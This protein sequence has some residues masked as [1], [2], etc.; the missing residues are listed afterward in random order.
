MRLYHSKKLVS[1]GIPS[2]NEELNVFLTYKALKKITNKLKKYNFEFIFVDNGSTD[3]TREK[4]AKLISKDKCVTGVFLSRNFGPEASGQAILDYARGEAFIGVACDLQDPASLIPKFIQKWE[5]GCHV[6]FGIYLKSNDNFLI[7]FMRK[8]FYFVYQKISNIDVPVNATGV[9]L[10]DKKA[11]EAL[12][13]LP[14]KYRFNRGLKV[15]IGL[16]TGYIFYNKKERKHGQSSYNIFNYIKHAERGIFGF[17]YLFLDGIIY[18]GFILVSLSFLFIL[19]YLTLFFLYGNPI[20][21]SVTILVAIVFFGGVNLLGLSVIGKYVQ[22]V[23]EET[24][25][26]PLYIINS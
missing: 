19:L 6:V 4:I 11:I 14:E 7:T 9:S 25:K 2:F 23:V 8:I 3:A 22:V 13:K 17:S 18:L 1:I 24:K 10:V 16:K 21:G 20:K 15:W 26:R 5:Q 12:K